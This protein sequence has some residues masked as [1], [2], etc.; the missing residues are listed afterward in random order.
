MVWLAGISLVRVVTTPLPH[1]DHLKTEMCARLAT[2][3]R[4]GRKIN[5]L[6]ALR[7]QSSAGG[8]PTL[9]LD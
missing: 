4:C 2:G 7:N 3:E 1:P 6:I 9:A 5:V 8:A